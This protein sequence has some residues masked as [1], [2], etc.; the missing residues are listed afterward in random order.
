M[1]FDPILALCSW[2]VLRQAQQSVVER[3]SVAEL[4]EVVEAR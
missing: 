2:P 1:H 3:N 4:V